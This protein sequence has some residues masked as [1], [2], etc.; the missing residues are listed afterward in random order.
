MRVY[1]TYYSVLEHDIKLL[2]WPTIKAFES[3]HSWVDIQWID[4]RTTATLME[5]DSQPYCAG[6]IVN[7]P[8]EI[9]SRNILHKKY[10]ELT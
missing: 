6:L 5:H 9:I 8:V 10:L 3:A 1:A 7:T 4:I 2:E